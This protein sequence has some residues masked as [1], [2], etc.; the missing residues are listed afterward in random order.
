[1][2]N[3]RLNRN[4]LGFGIVSAVL[5][6]AIS[7]T[8]AANV[9]FNNA[10][11]GSNWNVP[12]NWDPASLPGV[13]DDAILGSSISGEASVDVIVDSN[14]GTVNDVYLGDN[15]STSGILEI[16]TGGML[17]ANSVFVAD[18]GPPATGTL[19]LTGGTLNA[20]NIEI[21]SQDFGTLELN[22]TSLSGLSTFTLSEAASSITRAGAETISGDNLT[23]TNGATFTLFAGDSFSNKVFPQGGSTLEISN[24]TLTTSN[25]QFGTTSTSGILNRT[26]GTINVSHLDIVG[27][28]SITTAA[29]DV[30]NSI[31]EVRNNS[32]LTLGAD[33]VTPNIDV[34]TDSTF[35]MTGF[36]VG[37]VGTPVNSFDLSG[38][39]S[40]IIRTGSDN[41]HATTFNV[42]TDVTFTPDLTGPDVDTFDNLV[43]VRGNGTLDIGSGTFSMPSGELRLGTSSGETG[44]LSRIAGGGIDVQTFRVQ[45]AS[46]YDILASDAVSSSLLV[47][48]GGV[49][50]QTVD[51]TLT[52]GGSVSITGGGVGGAIYN[53]QAGTT[54]SSNAVT[55]GGNDSNDVSVLNLGSALGTG[56]LNGSTGAGSLTVNESGELNGWGT[57]NM[58]GQLNMFGRMVANGFGASIADLDL[59]S[60][61]S[62]NTGTPA[63]D[64]LIGEDHG[65]YAINGGRLIMPETSVSSGSGVIAR[66]GESSADTDDIDLINSMEFTFNNVG[67]GANLAVNI[68][69][70]DHE[71]TKQI[72]I[73]PLGVFDISSDA[74]T[75]DEFDL[76]IRYDDIL[77]DQ[78]GIN[79]SDL[80][81]LSHI[82]GIWQDITSSVNITDK[83]IT[84]SGVTAFGQFAI[85]TD[86]EL[87]PVPEPGTGLL[88][89]GCMGAMLLRRR[90]GRQSSK[91]A[92]QQMFEI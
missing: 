33:V 90:K 43:H 10:T 49:L 7:N 83:F 76:T 4:V 18:G 47:G 13:G 53:L 11:A 91:N 19:R 68:L 88:V 69:A 77:A 58:T 57:P 66:V 70:S 62:L 45:G 87:A 50:N 15:G 1:M 20:T 14:V 36:D 85:A 78:L 28:S 80:K 60:F 42:L 65:W 56:T 30:I 61:G 67:A 73:N 3:R 21:G 41:I 40:T 55:I 81:L 9:Y 89:L 5:A 38:P 48:T 26:T 63:R 39:G 71:E 31:L 86:F 29:G 25:L 72:L 51:L 24:L 6:C 82:D 34:E 44:I 2:F 27:G 17:T 37:T 16:T 8:N 22:G 92:Q 32:T 52:S 84:A 75:F 54:L 23:I 46:S 79:Q 59:T 35:I 12:G 74:L 64:N